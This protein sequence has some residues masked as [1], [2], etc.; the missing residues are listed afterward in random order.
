LASPHLAGNH[1]APEQNGVT[2]EEAR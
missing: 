2:A 1:A